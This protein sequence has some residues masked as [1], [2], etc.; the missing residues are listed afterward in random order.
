VPNVLSKFRLPHPVRLYYFGQHRW[1]NYLIDIQETLAE[2]ESRQVAAQSDIQ[3]TLESGFE[4]L[5][6]AI[7]NLR[8]DFQ[9][10]F[11]LMVDRLDSQVRLLN[12][13]VGQLEEIR[14]AVVLRRTTE[15]RE[16]FSIGQEA[17]HNG[18][19]PE[20]LENF[21][22]AEQ[23]NK[24]NF[25]LQLQ[26]GKLLLYGKNKQ[27]SVINIPSAEQHLLL[28]ARYA[29]RE[30]RWSKC[31]GEALFH[32][33]LAAYLIAEQELDG[34][35]PQEMRTCLGRALVTLAEAVEVWPEFTEL[36]YLRAKCCALVG[37]N[38]KALANIQIL[39]DMDR[40]YFS[41]MSADNDLRSVRIDAERTF[42]NAIDAPG[43]NARAA[44][45]SLLEIRKTLALAEQTLPKVAEDLTLIAAAK[46][47]LAEAEALLHSLKV[48]IG[49]FP[50]VLLPVRRDLE[51]VIT[52]PVIDFSGDPRGPYN[53]D[54]FVSPE[55]QLQGAVREFKW[56]PSRVQFYPSVGKDDITLREELGGK[57]LLNANV[58]DYLL[59]H[60]AA[61]PENWKTDE[62]GRPRRISFWGTIYTIPGGSP[63][64]AV[65]YLYWDKSAWKSGY[66]TLSCTHHQTVWS[67]RSVWKWDRR[68]ASGY[69][70]TSPGD[71]VALYR[72]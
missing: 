32:A 57:P 12:Q 24:I 28:A 59:T 5:G 69:D 60:P 41:K 21:L 22:A 65:R 19:L 45:A 17:L 62:V 37:E 56:D 30:Q 25:P 15:A 55:D 14:N 33:A 27:D 31:R 1:D 38:G 58:L 20:A 54:W 53:T 2:S 71:V 49:A 34:G 10:G 61:I 72:A 44:E 63:R 67:G 64:L 52:R 48:D 18:L 43:P 11:T 36:Y 42:Q 26:I 47:R 40:R 68:Y 13:I 29:G 23:I 16:L 46:S 51:R 9:W 70:L 66:S 8:A 39:S 35:R 6:D 4:N 7:E 3:D 50:A